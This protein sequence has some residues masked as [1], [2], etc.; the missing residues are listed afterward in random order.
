MLERVATYAAPLIIVGDFNI[1]MDDVAD[2]NAGK[3]LDIAAAHGLIQH[4]K[5]ATHCGGHTLDLV[6]TPNDL[7]VTILPIDPPLLSDHSA[8]IVNL[9]QHPFDS[10]TT[11]RVLRRW[12]SLDVRAFAADLMTCDLVNELREDVSTAFSCYDTTLRSQ[13]DRHAPSVTKRVRRC[14]SA[15]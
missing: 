14:R 8:V 9:G 10:A 3:L 2:T 13:L 6:L 1:H 4:V 15:R 11:V 7:N 12:H 5:A